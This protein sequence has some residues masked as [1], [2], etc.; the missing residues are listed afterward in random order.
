MKT[1]DW[2]EV[3]AH[4]GTPM[5]DTSHEE[6]T[7]ESL[8]TGGRLKMVNNSLKH[9]IIQCFSNPAWNEYCDDIIHLWHNTTQIGNECVFDAEDGERPGVQVHQRKV[10]DLCSVQR[11]GGVDTAAD[12]EISWLHFRARHGH[13]QNTGQTQGTQAHRSTWS[14]LNGI[15][16]MNSFISDWCW[17]CWFVFMSGLN[18]CNNSN[19]NLTHV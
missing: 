6:N 3:G 16:Y 15:F 1:W 5:E 11:G 7:Y 4:F 18:T 13:H 17:D 8:C 2:T 9:I 14:L 10:G 19:M 12:S